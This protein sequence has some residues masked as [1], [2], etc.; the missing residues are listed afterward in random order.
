MSKL[1]TGILKWH[2]YCVQLYDKTAHAHSY[3]CANIAHG[4]LHIIII[5]V[6]SLC[7]NSNIFAC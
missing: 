1:N 2:R 3:K 5:M 6:Y 4:V 7:C